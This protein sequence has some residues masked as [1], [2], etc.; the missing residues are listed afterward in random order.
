MFAIYA[1]F[2]RKHFGIASASELHFDW[3]RHNILDFL[4]NGI[5]CHTETVC[6]SIQRLATVAVA[7]CLR[8]YTVA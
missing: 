4:E 8:K 3:L 5:G 1:I 7:S 6:S 2:L